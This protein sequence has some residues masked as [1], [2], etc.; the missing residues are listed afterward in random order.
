MHINSRPEKGPVLW[1]GKG[2]LWSV[3]AHLVNVLGGGPAQLVAQ[4]SFTAS[5]A[6]KATGL[7]HCFVLGVETLA[8][9]SQLL[10]EVTSGGYLKLYG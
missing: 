9:S 8:L 6:L 2:G 5:I 3:F 10:C 7:C 4:D 1:S